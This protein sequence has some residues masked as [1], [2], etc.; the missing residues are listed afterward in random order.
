ME[1]L[2]NNWDLALAGF[3]LAEK[4]VKLTPTKYD[5]ILID[6]VWGGLKKLV[7]K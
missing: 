4:I 1:W 6:M 2:S 3:F 5:D 7:G